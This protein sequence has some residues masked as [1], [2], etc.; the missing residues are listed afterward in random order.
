[1]LFQLRRRSIQQ[2]NLSLVFFARHQ[3]M[4]GK[5]RDEMLPGILF[6]FAHGRILDHRIEFGGKFVKYVECG[7][8]FG[9]GYLGLIDAKRV[10][11]TY[12]NRGA[13]SYDSGPLRHS[14]APGKGDAL[15]RCAPVI[16]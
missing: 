5:L 11:P 6:E 7:G 4:L 16:H 8:D 15:F 2:R 10:L 9:H 12:S 1:M 14:G 13:N 3:A